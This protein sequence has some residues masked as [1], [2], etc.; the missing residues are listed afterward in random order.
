MLRG[1]GDEAPGAE[2]DAIE[3]EGSSRM[4]AAALAAKVGDLWLEPHP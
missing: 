2:F 3:A 4:L 1:R